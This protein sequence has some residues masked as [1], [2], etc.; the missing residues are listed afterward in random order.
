MAE[1]NTLHNIIPPV[2]LINHQLGEDIPP[3]LVEV[4]ELLVL[5][6]D[7][8]ANFNDDFFCLVFACFV[9][10][11]FFVSFLAIFDPPLSRVLFRFLGSDNQIFN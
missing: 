2:T 7:F 3:T 1:A 6:N 10:A 5:L 9:A 8:L 11:T 4:L